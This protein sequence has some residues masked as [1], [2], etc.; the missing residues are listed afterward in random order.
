MVTHQVLPFV[1]GSTGGT[2][3][4]NMRPEMKKIIALA[5]LSLALVGCGPT[6]N[7]AAIENSYNTN[8]PTKIG[9]LPD[10]RS[11]Q[12]VRIAVPGSVHPHYVYFVE[13]NSTVNRVVSEG[14]TTRIHTTAF[15]E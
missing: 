12:R 9:T 15:L 6:Q 1:T 7:E 5:V 14:K 10:G 13:G 8:S 4:T 2:F 11:I 3:L